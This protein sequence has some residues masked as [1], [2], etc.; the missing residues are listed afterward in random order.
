MIYRRVLMATDDVVYEAKY[1]GSRKAV[2]KVL[3]IYRRISS[4][5]PDVLTD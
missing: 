5:C 3:K 2:K 1:K 4:E